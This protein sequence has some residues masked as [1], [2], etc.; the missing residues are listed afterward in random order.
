VSPAGGSAHA[1]GNR[2]LVIVNP[3]A[4]GG[5][6]ERRWPAL[7]DELHRLGLAFDWAP[8]Y[9]REAATSLARSAASAGVG[10]IVAVGGDGTLNEVVNGAVTPGVPMVSIGAILTGRGR[11]AVRNLQL[12][13]DPRV[14]ARRV[15][16]GVDA[17]VDL[18]RA[19]W[20]G[21]R[22]RWVVGA[23]GAGFDAAVAARAAARGGHGTLPYV[24]AVLRTIS[25]HAP[26]DAQVDA[27][28]APAW[29][30]RLTAAV[31][32]NGAY[33]GGGMKIAPSADP[34]D[35]RLDLV[36]LGNLGR[37]E[38]LRWLPTVYRG[39]HLRHPEV[40]ARAARR[41]TIRAATPLPMHVDGEAV[42]ATPVTL[43]IAP[44]A[45]RLRR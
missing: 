6:T 28:G 32:A 36:V 3:A 19:E 33:Y 31:V 18:V 45:L 21:G 17:T 44:G 41:V 30:G 35:G 39:A 4:G 10:L 20:P 2:C 22:H 16:E 38:L 42:A 13:D 34:G 26:V 7:R 40:I 24:R 9:A 8:T 14:A 29:S 27:D 43:S 12:A 1:P 25:A 15:V 11:D 23:A 5:R 37:L